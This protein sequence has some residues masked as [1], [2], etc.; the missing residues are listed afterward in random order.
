MKRVFILSLFIISISKANVINYI[1]FIR[2]H[3][4]ASPL[5]YSKT[6]SYAAKKHAIYLESNREF[7]HSENRNKINFYGAM[8]WN[9]ILNAGFGSKAVVEN[10]SFGEKNYT[11]SIDKLMATVYHRLAFLD[12]KIDSIGFSK[13]DNIYVYDMGNSKISSLCKQEF[14]S[15]TQVVDGLC[16]NSYK[17]IPLKIFQNVLNRRKKYSKKIIIYPYVN[18]KN[19][20]ISLVDERPKFTYNNRGYGLPISVIFNSNYYTDI[21]VKKFELKRRNYIVPSKIVTFRNDRA[22][23]LKKNSFILLPLQKLKHHTKYRVFL[24]AMIDGKLKKVSWRFK[25]R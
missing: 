20:A 11:A 24:Q 15:S 19:V 3:S 14:H 10:I 8:P 7:G 2:V 5:K 22:K 4:G 18:Q 25:T 16:R 23:K 17:Q 1:N 9:R 21:R 12:T 13:F 6:L